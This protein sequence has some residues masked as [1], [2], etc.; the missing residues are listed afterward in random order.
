MKSKKISVVSDRDHKKTLVG[1]W[2]DC[3]LNWA[4]RKLRMGRIKILRVVAYRGRIS[5]D[6]FSV[7]QLY[8]S[9]FEAVVTVGS[10]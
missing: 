5:C 6:E 9:R 4:S 8:V 7:R 1:Q 3:Q 10:W 2:G